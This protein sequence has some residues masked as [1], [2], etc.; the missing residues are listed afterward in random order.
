V[1]ETCRHHAQEDCS[2]GS[3]QGR[4]PKEGRPE[5]RQS[6][7]RLLAYKNQVGGHL[8]VD[9]AALQRLPHSQQALGRASTLPALP[10]VLL[11]L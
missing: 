1:P 7:L 5:A 3:R 2:S 11:D 8:A 4:C 9:Q 6:A 10:D